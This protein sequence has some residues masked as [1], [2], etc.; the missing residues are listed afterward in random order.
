V[1]K[2]QEVLTGVVERFYHASGNRPAKLIVADGG[3][4]FELT[5]YP[6]SGVEQPWDEQTP[7]NTTAW[8]SSSRARSRC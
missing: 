3:T 5:I 4:T 2:D 8:H 7:L 6:P 1:P